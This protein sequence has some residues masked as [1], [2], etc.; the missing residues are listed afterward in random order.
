[1]LEGRTQTEGG[2]SSVLL[3]ATFSSAHSRPG[4]GS[5]FLQS[6]HRTQGLTQGH[7]GEKKAEW[8]KLSC[9][10]SNG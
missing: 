9:L 4:E 10:H 6:A 8:E 3:T 7:H 2:N 5:S 1:M